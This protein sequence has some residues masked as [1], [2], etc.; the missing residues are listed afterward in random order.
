MGPSRICMLCQGFL[1]YPWPQ[2]P[3]YHQQWTAFVYTNFPA[4]KIQEKAYLC[5]RHFTK[6]S[7]QNWDTYQTTKSEGNGNE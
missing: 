2:D 3:E 1:A 4:K 5:H 6:G 7:F